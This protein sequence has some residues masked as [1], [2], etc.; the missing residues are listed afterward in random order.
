MS[1]PFL[2]GA[3][4]NLGVS[5]LL[6]HILWC[7]MCQSS[8]AKRRDPFTKGDFM[9]PKATKSRA[10]ALERWNPTQESCLG[11]RC[12]L[13]HW[14]YRAS[15]L[16]SLLF[17]LLGRQH[18]PPLHAQMDQK[19]PLPKGRFNSWRYMVVPCPNTDSHPKC[20]FQ[21]PRK[22][23]RVGPRSHPCSNQLWPNMA[24]A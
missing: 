15:G 6:S 4:Q 20:Q 7:S 3:P 16:C 13:F 21:S 2:P 24:A 12:F 19:W 23:N 17:D 11:P 9:E 10:G 14:D 8:R 22:G 5:L 1:A 18:L